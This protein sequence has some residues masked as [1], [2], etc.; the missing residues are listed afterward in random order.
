MVIDI[1]HIGLFLKGDS[2]ISLK[3]DEKLSRCSSRIELNYYNF[4]GRALFLNNVFK[5]FYDWK[6][7]GEGVNLLFTVWSYLLEFLSS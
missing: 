5:V 2:L 6:L 4:Y 7:R 1:L 3:L